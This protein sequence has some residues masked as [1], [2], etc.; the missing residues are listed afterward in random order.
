VL[1]RDAEVREAQQDYQ[2]ALQALERYLMQPPVRSDNW[3]PFFYALKAG[4]LAL[5]LEAP[6]Q[7]MNYYVLAY[8][9]GLSSAHLSD[10]IRLVARWHEERG[11]PHCALQL[12]DRYQALDPL[13]FHLVADRLSRQMLK[14][15][16][17]SSRGS[18][19]TCPRYQMLEKIQIKDGERE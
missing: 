7:A 6:E 8:E 15:V 1:L 12:V 10:R 19:T 9:R 11:E 18:E 14:D 4:D 3:N 17:N 16:G 5:E 2:G 13:L